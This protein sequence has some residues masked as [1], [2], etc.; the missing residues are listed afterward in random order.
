MPSRNWKEE[1]HHTVHLEIA[2]SALLDDLKVFLTSEENIMAH[3][4]LSHHNFINRLRGN[5]G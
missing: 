5:W 3:K 4:K 1:L 2:H